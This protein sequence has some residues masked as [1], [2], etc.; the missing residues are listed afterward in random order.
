MP[1]K[2]GVPFFSFWVGEG[3]N[4]IFGSEEEWILGGEEKFFKVFIF[5]SFFAFR[6]FYY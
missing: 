1:F 4:L 6:Y 5:V 3:V 2:G